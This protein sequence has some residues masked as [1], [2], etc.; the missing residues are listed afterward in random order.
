M[1]NRPVAARAALERCAHYMPASAEIR[2]QLEGEFGPDGPYPAA[3]YKKYA[4]RPTAKPVTESAA[5]GRLSDAR[6]AFE[7]LTQLTPDDPAAW[8]NLGVVLAWLSELPKAVAALARSIELETDDRRAEEAGALAEVLRC[9]HGMEN[10]TD[11]V[12]HSFVMPIRDPQPVQRL[13]Q[14][15]SQSGK[16][17][18]VRA[19]RES[20]M[21]MGMLVEEMP[22]LLAVGAVNLAR[23]TARMV[24][25]Q[26]VIRLTGGNRDAVAKEADDMRTALQLAVEQPAE[27]TSPL[28]FGEVV[29]EALAE[30]SG[31]GDEAALEAKLREHA[32]HYFESA[33]IHKPLKAL[34]GNT[35][36]DAVGSKVLRKHAFG[37]VKFLEDCMAS[38]QPH[39]QVGEQLIPI[40]VYNF[41]NLRHKL[42]LEYV[43][44]EPPKVN[45]PPEPTPTTTSWSSIE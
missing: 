23:V 43:S 37:V 9:G 10:E 44:A 8:F 3:A 15:Y 18:G 26:G 5:T 2:S 36:V 35:P 7:D 17:R 24:I 28:M 1:L 16:L 29:R 32:A 42:G 6:K 14:A 19:S 4:F 11:H 21:V 40:E 34:S 38:V 12:A 41:D 25:G 33:W 45:V 31:S 13:L 27:G 22:S 39:K 20:G 30:P